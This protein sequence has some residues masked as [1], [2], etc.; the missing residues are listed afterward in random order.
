MYNLSTYITI[1]GVAVVGD[2]FDEDAPFIKLEFC[3][4]AANLADHAK[5]HIAQGA[6]S[7]LLD[8]FQNLHKNTKDETSA[9][10]GAE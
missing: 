7:A 10:P 6:A 8:I 9:Q 5:E 3:N 1:S 4:E 2:A